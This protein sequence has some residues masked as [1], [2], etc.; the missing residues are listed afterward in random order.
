M[1]ELRMS[2]SPD[3]LVGV[4][5]LDATYFVDDDGNRIPSMGDD[6]TGRIMYTADGSM[7]AMTGRGDRNFPRPA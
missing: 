4:W 6:P 7:A 3:D 1:G 5:T 2:L